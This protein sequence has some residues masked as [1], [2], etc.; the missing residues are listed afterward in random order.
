MSE[1]LRIS[2]DRLRA[3]CEV[4]LGHLAETEG[5]TVELLRDYFWSIDDDSLYDV[6]KEPA[7]L[8][9]GQVSESWGHL[10]DL[11]DGRTDIPTRHLVWLSDVLRAL[12]T[13]V[14]RKPLTAES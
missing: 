9:I 5:E 14:S 6:Y 13:P 3:A 4:V 10:E 11:L 12:G 2:V 7:Q 1:P 8:G